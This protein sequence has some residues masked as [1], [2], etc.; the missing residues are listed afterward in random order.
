[1][2]PRRCLHSLWA[3]F[4]WPLL[5]VVLFASLDQL[6][7]KL[8]L[9]CVARSDLP[10]K[11]TF[12]LNLIYTRNTGISFGLLKAGSFWGAGL[13][14]LGAAAIIFGLCFWYIEA[15]TRLLRAGLLC[16]I[17]GAIGNMMDRLT[18]GGVIDFIDFH[19]SHYHFPTFNVADTMISLGTALILWDALRAKT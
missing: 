3:H 10:I 12:F 14:V 2:T 18:Y 11:V 5:T 19:W 17:A 16:I 9:G 7:K 1:M 8:I 6:S 15:K 4:R 13:L